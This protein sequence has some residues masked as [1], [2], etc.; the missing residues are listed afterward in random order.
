MP[1]HRTYLLAALVGVALAPASAQAKTEPVAFDTG[2]IV[3][4]DGNPDHWRSWRVSG[5][6]LAAHDRC[7]Y[8][9]DASRVL[10]GKPVTQGLPL[11]CMDP[12]TRSLRP[13]PAP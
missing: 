3:R 2:V 13:D 5:P 10:R 4:T 7:Q 9:I 11:R 1:D 8:R 12:Y 6:R